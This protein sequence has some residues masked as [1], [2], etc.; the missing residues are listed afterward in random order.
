MKRYVL[1]IISS[2]AISMMAVA[3][4]FTVNVGDSKLF[5]KITDAKQ[6]TAEVTYEGSISQKKGNSLSGEVRIPATVR[7]EGT[8]YSITAI[9]S[10]AL[11]NA[12]SIT[13]V[14]MPSSIKRIGDFAFEGCTHLESVIFPGNPVS[15]GQGTFFRCSSLRNLSLGSDWTQLDFSMFRWS[16]SLQVINIP[17]R[18]QK[19]QGLKTLRALNRIE[20]DANNPRYASENGVLYDKTFVTLLCVPRAQVGVL[21]VHEGTVSILWGAAID[22]TGIT[23]ITLPSTLQKLS[24]REFSRMSNLQCIVCQMTE[25]I[26]TATTAGTEVS[27]FVV[28]NPKVSFLVPK[29]SLKAWKKALKNEA[30]DFTEIRTNKPEGI[31]DQIADTPYRIETT[32]MVAPKN[33]KALG[34]K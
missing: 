34:K 25:P 27:L 18:M 5:F 3:H 17:A 2:A 32:Q 10:K 11:A 14:I 23:E 20:V 19:I 29:A 33:I 24:F 30:A 15:F 22:C 13:S 7:H 6:H 8:V 28:A 12:D 1:T 21:N 16:D 26:K 4:D 31:A 9:G